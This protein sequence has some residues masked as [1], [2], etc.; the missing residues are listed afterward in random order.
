MALERGFDVARAFTLE[1]GSLRL[2]CLRFA[3]VTFSGLP[4]LGASWAQLSVGLARSPVLAGSSGRL[5]MTRL[6]LLI[7][8]LGP[9]TAILLLIALLA[10]LT[11]QLILFPGTVAWFE[12]HRRNAP[13]AVFAFVLHEGTPQLW[14]MMRV[15][16]L[17][18]VASALGIA[19]LHAL[20]SRLILMGTIR[21]WDSG[22]L[23]VVL[24]AW[25]WALSALWLTFVGAGAFWCRVVLA[26][27]RRRRV[28]SAG[29]LVLRVFGRRPLTGP[30]LFIALTGLFQL[31]LGAYL[32]YW[33][34]HPADSS[35]GAWLRTVIWLALVWLQAFI[36]LGLLRIAQRIYTGADCADLRKRGERPWYLLRRLLRHPIPAARSWSEEELSKPK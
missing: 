23:R 15:S 3:L 6:A 22:T 14:A 21:G 30:G 27:D 12:A 18:M 19:L 7:V 1:E 33:R 20:F 29:L 5:D 17:A 4:V 25:Q 10:V 16:L 26:A 9:A 36:W 32:F 8:D 28:R 34:Q 35:V 24:P 2:I 31:V 11:G 13:R